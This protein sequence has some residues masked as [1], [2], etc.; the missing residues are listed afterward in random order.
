VGVHCLFPIVTIG[1]KQRRGTLN[2]PYSIEDV[3]L[4]SVPDG[5]NSLTGR[6]AAGSRCSA[7]DKCS[8]EL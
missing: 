8:R 4:I 5:S 3:F 2:G 6:C 1:D 7:R